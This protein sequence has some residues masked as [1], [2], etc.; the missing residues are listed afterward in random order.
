MSQR[1]ASSTSGWTPIYTR[2]SPNYSPSTPVHRPSTAANGSTSPLYSPTSPVYSPT[3]PDFGLGSSAYRAS[4]PADRVTSFKYSPTSAAYSPSTPVF[5]TNSPSEIEVPHL[6]LNSPNPADVI[7]TIA[8][9][10]SYRVELIDSTRQQASPYPRRVS[11]LL[12]M[13]KATN[14]TRP[15]ESRQLSDA[16]CGS[17]VVAPTSTP[18]PDPSTSNPG[19][20]DANSMSGPAYM[21]TLTR[22]IS[23]IDV[24]EYKG[25]PEDVSEKAQEGSEISDTDSLAQ[26]ASDLEVVKLVDHIPDIDLNKGREGTS[27]AS[28]EETKPRRTSLLEESTATII[29]STLP[30]DASKESDAASTQVSNA[31]PKFI[32]EFIISKNVQPAPNTGP[33][34]DKWYL[35]NIHGHGFFSSHEIKEH[36]CLATITI[37]LAPHLKLELSNVADNKFVTENIKNIDITLKPQ[38]NAPFWTYALAFKNNGPLENVEVPEKNVSGK[39]V[40]KATYSEIVLNES[41]ITKVVD[42]ELVGYKVLGGKVAEER[43]AEKKV[44]EEK[45]SK[46]KVVEEQTVEDK[47]VQED[48]NSSSNPTTSRYLALKDLVMTVQPVWGEEY[49]TEVIDQLPARDVNLLDNITCEL[50][51]LVVKHTGANAKT[52]LVGCC[53]ALPPKFIC[54]NKTPADDLKFFQTIVN[55]VV[56]TRGWQ[57]DKLMVF[58]NDGPPHLWK[59]ADEVWD[60]IRRAF[61]EELGNASWSDSKNYY[62]DARCG[63]GGIYCLVDTSA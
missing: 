51:K 12:P 17:P 21:D 33:S 24:K 18:N 16:R 48:S 62:V 42:H 11:G 3:T 59:G 19:V 32:P 6:D 44:A 43:V 34:A 22:A 29:P 26:F 23:A 50:L 15:N 38:E 35:Y 1:S 37:S 36:K 7:S 5:S 58:F 54:T 25:V 13:A 4:N 30:E 31:I 49:S 2:R 14:K 10:K 41:K 8:A 40:K 52:I 46:E 20:A 39:E 53:K 61:P 60:T 45:V 27:Q 47:I 28:R 9:N 63:R 57:A 56:D 55:Q